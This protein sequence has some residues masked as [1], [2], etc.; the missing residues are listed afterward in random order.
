MARP[1]A[2][3]VEDESDLRELIELSLAGMDL[4]VVGVG[5]LGEAQA[6]LAAQTFALCL[7]DLRLPDGMSL[8]LVERIGRDYP[9]TPVAVLTAYGNVET[10][11]L[12]L[13]AGAFDFVAKPVDVRQLRGLVETA[14][15]LA[16]GKPAVDAAARMIGDSP[17]MMQARATIAKLARSQAPVYIS[18]ESGSG[19]ELAARLIHELSPR[20][21]GAFVPVNCGAIPAELLESEF[22]GHKKGSFTGA[23]AD[24]IG[25]FQAAN[26]GTLLLDEVAELPMP[27]Q[28][29][30]L[31]AIQEKAIR[32]IGANAEQ[33]VDVRLI[34][35]TH[36]K[37]HALVERGA[38]R[39]DLYYRINVIELPMPPLRER[40]EDIAVLARHILAKLDPAGRVRLSPEADAALLRY[41]FPG[42]IRELENILERALALCDGDVIS[43]DDLHLPGGTPGMGAG[44]ATGESAMS[45]GGVVERGGAAFGGFDPALGAGYGSGGGAYAPGSPP[46]AGGAG[47]VAA[48][49]IPSTGT[50]DAPLEDYIEQLERDRILKALE[51]NRYNK[52]KTADALGITFRALRYRLKKLGIE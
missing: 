52:T 40:R 43:A 16:A 42:N 34:S 20:A 33:P 29:K 32:P 51:A 9:H 2:L 14:L 48:T 3:V 13:K 28:V 25:L 10:A 41:A 1:A 45:N 24:K 6:K 7:T 22:F 46:L 17:A 5:S 30:L 4:E 38:F 23:G 15:R 12:A 37:L 8:S 11:V 19:K 27:M 47:A 26:G 39:Q 21:A 44:M 35:A 31:R 50:K 49:G 36:K 18:G